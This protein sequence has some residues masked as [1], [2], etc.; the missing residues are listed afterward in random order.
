[1]PGE[2]HAF[3]FEKKFK[4]KGTADLTPSL[5]VKLDCEFPL[6]GIEVSLAKKI[7]KNFAKEYEKLIK[8]QLVHFEKWLKEK[9]KNIDDAKALEKTIVKMGVPEDEAGCKN[10]AAELDK[11]SKMKSAIEGLEKDFDT[12]SGNWAKNV[13]DQQAEIAIMKARKQ[14]GAKLLKDKKRRLV[15]GKVVKGILL[16]SAIAIGIAATVLTAGTA[17]PLVLGLSIAAASISGATGIYSFAQTVKRDNDIEK[18]TLKTVQAEVDALATAMKP[19]E[20]SSLAK[21]V[22]ELE[23]MIKLRKSELAELKMELKKIIVALDGQV[24]AIHTLQSGS[25]GL[26]NAKDLNKQQKKYTS[27]RKGATEIATKIEKANSIVSQ[28]EKLINTL[29]EF[30]VKMDEFAKFY[31]SNSIGGNLKR[32]FTSVDAFKD[33]AGSLGS[34]KTG[35]GF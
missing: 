10:L 3:K 32:Y 5:D 29:K 22:L 26:L 6:E 11:L 7:E 25:A 33:L 13:V 17:A 31:K 30:G 4:V 23:N 27:M 8:G 14:A 12:L 24:K 28:G 19:I 34:F 20:A 1:M 9:Q 21:H 18:K 2:N 16:V 15:L 35:A